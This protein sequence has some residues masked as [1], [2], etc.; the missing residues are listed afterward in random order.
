[1]LLKA[2]TP[3]FSQNLIQFFLRLYFSFVFLDVRHLLN[4]DRSQCLHMEV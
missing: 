4:S 3:Y 1:M 2:S